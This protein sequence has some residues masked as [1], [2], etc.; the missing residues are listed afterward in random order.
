MEHSW[1]SVTAN[2]ILI[3]AVEV[4]ARNLI[5]A[6][7]E[8]TWVQELSVPRTF[9]TSV[10]VRTILDH[11]EKNGSGLDLPAEVQ[12]VLSLHK[13]WEANPFVAQFII[14]MEEARNKLVCDQLP[15]TDNMLVS[16]ATYMFLKS[17]SFPRNRP[18]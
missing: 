14:N 8:L 1:A 15:I 10:R 5:L 2:Q 18:I 6:N 12:L 17:N 16:F 11:L 13:L 7:V 4:G 3:R 9:Y